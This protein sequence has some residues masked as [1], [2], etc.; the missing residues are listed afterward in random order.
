MTDRY[1]IT[2]LKN[3]FLELRQIRLK[4]DD[5]VAG[6]E[7]KGN[8][9]QVYSLSVRQCAPLIFANLSAWFASLPNRAQPIQNLKQ[10]QGRNL[11]HRILT[12]HGFTRSY[13]LPR[14]PRR[15]RRDRQVARGKRHRGRLG[16][17]DEKRLVGRTR[18]LGA[19]T[20]VVAAETVSES[21]IATN[22]HKPTDCP[23]D[24]RIANPLLARRKR[25]EPRTDAFG[26]SEGK[27][28]GQPT[29]RARGG[30]GRARR[31]RRR[32]D[33]SDPVE[34]IFSNAG[35]TATAAGDDQTD[36]SGGAEGVS[37]DGMDRGGVAQKGSGAE[38]GAGAAAI[39][40][41]DEEGDHT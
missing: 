39:E 17:G 12:G 36:Q 31:G 16:S 29:K 27:D 19:T 5:T 34:K 14:H 33:R 32:R 20:E 8:E 21:D 38:P 35:G 30:G 9:V 22:C 41:R 18:G 37:A 40:G 25:C 11:Y 26:S 15:V 10:I 28:S 1:H 23:G 2:L 4:S 6:Y 7:I 13:E 24:R 3:Q